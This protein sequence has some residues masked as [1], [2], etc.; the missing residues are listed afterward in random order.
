MSNVHAGKDV[1]YSAFDI[2]KAAA[3]GRSALRRAGSKLQRMKIKV[4]FVQGR[5]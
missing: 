2:D 1:Y 5:F 4:C 3:G